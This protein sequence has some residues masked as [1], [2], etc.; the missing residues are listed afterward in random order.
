AR[1]LLWAA[2]GA[3]VAGAGIAGFHV[4]V[5]QHW[6][7]GLNTCAGQGTAGLSRDA[8]KDQLLATAPARCDEIPWSLAGVSMAGWNGIF[9]LGLAA[10][11]AAGLWRIGPWR[12]GPWRIGPRGAA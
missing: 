7:T 12:I 1:L 9:S 5:E 10:A 4:G 2:L 3:L 8:L 6:W 11:V